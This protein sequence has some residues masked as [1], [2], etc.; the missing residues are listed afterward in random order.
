MA[1]MAQALPVGPLPEQI[2]VT[3]MR[4]DVVDVGRCCNTTSLLAVD[5]QGMLGKEAFAGLLPPVAVPTLAAGATSLLGCLVLGRDWGR[6]L[7]SLGSG[8]HGP[9]V[10]ARNAVRHHLSR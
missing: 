8:W 6:W 3:T 5:A 4:H 9:I 2:H 1:R 7:V 10:V